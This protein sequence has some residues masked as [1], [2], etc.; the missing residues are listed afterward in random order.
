MID[1]SS[2]ILWGTKDGPSKAS[3][4]GKMLSQMSYSGTT[5]IIAT[6]R[7][8]YGRDFLSQEEITSQISDLNEYASNNDMVARVLPGAIIVADCFITQAYENLHEMTLASSRYLLLELVG[9]SIP[10]FWDELT[11]ELARLGL[12]TV[13]KCA[14]THPYIQ[15]NTDTIQKMTSHGILFAISARSILGRNGKI[16]FQAANYMLEKNLASF[17]C[18]DAR[19][20][21][22][23]RTQ[24]E[25]A[26]YLVTKKMGRETA[27]RLFYTN[28][29]KIIFNESIF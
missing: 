24:L 3:A 17:I 18:S 13:C 2:Q 22:L 16:A 21:Y 20:P 6:P 26:F 12:V 27:E 15:Q 14:E 4:S 9:Y 28:P 29:S 10:S 23:H 1:I 25:K 8:V 19:S 11:L 5:H 7:Y